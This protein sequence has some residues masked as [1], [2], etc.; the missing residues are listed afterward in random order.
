MGCTCRT[1]HQQERHLSHQRGFSI[2]TSA[3]MSVHTACFARETSP[4]N[5]CDIRMVDPRV[6]NQWADGVHDN[7][8]I[9]VIASDDLYELVT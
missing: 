1:T 2:G 3:L 4:N 6:K 7:H 9:R 5:S 8:R